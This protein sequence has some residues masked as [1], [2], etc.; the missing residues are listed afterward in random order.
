MKDGKF[1]YEL[2]L[3]F[4]KS[5]INFSNSNYIKIK[6]IINLN[7]DLEIEINNNFI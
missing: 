6:N 3:L 7:Q 5:N 1:N 2:I 4:K